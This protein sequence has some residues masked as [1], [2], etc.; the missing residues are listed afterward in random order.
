MKCINPVIKNNETNKFFNF[1]KYI[2]TNEAHNVNNDIKKGRFVLV[3]CRKCLNCKTLLKIK[4][5]NRLEAESYNW[6]YIYFITLTYNEQHN[7]EFL[8]KRDITL[9]IKLLRRMGYKFKYFYS[10]EYGDKTLRPHFHM[11]M[12][13]NEALNLRRLKDTPNGTL[14]TDDYLEK[15]WK[16]GYL[17]IGRDF[18][19][20][21]IAYVA[22]YV[23][24]KMDG[25]NHYKSYYRKKTLK[26]YGSN[27]TFKDYLECDK[28][29]QYIVRKKNNPEFYQA[30]L[31]L[32]VNVDMKY[33]KNN[34]DMLRLKSRHNL[35]N[36]CIKNNFGF[37]FKDDN[38]KKWRWLINPLTDI[39]DAP[40]L[41]FTQ[42]MLLTD[43]V[44]NDDFLVQWRINKNKYLSK[45]K[46]YDFV[47]LIRENQLEYFDKYKKNK[48]I[49]TND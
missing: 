5:I 44:E 24:K 16:R 22:G 48:N 2:K 7:P 23:A 35:D 41:T 33:I 29:I 4:W 34:N 43:Y 40:D 15:L 17:W 1:N 46:H 36:I 38:L 25:Y 20:K 37:N 11:I 26:Y 8:S 39:A 30:S 9:W 6:N 45:L 27:K 18:M 19:S 32:G 10:G 21:G 42:W 13:T 3:P 12:F 28:W 47:S 49:Y 14:Y 31:G